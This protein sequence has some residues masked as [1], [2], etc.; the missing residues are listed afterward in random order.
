MFK[1]SQMDKLCYSLTMGY[2]AV[3]RNKLL[4]HATTAI[5]LEKKFAEQ[6]KN[7]SKVVY[8]CIKLQKMQSES[9][10]TAGRSVVAWDWGQE[11]FTA[12]DIGNVLE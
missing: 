2:S 6:E 10:G 1:N 9:T 11:G 4:T 5:N 8:I 12:E 3:K 7:S